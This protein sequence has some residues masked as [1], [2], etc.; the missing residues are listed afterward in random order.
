[1]TQVAFKKITK[2]W[3]ALS[4]LITVEP[5]TVYYIQNR[6]DKILYACEGLEKPKNDEG[7]K[8][9]SCEVLMYKKGA[10]TLY[11]RAYEEDCAIN[12]SSEG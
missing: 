9:P 7:I 11:L 12:I 8:V 6:G 1:M 5:E 3:V 4:D 2:Q 10:Q